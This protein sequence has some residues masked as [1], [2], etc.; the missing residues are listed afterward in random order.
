MPFYA[1]IGM[2]THSHLRN[3]ENKP[4]NAP[5]TFNLGTGRFPRFHSHLLSVELLP[6]CSSD[7]CIPLVLLKSFHCVSRIVARWSVLYPQPLFQTLLLLS[8]FSC[9]ELSHEYSAFSKYFQVIALPL[10]KPFFLKT[11]TLFSFCNKRLLI[12]WG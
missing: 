6:L 3:Y 2:S 10:C 5:C 1:S 8:R 11:I 9:I 12:H 4:H 7:L